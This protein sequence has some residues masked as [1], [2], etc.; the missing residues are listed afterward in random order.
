MAVYWYVMLGLD[1]LSEV[2][3]A[4]MRELEPRLDHGNG[5]APSRKTDGQ[6]QRA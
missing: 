6:D 2:N 5:A 1:S 4:T 3:A